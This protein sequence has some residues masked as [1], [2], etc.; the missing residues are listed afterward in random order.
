M[1]ELNGE[2]PLHYRGDCT[3][4]PEGLVFGPDMYGG[5]WKP[6]RAEY[7]PAADRTTMRF[8]PHFEGI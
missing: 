1:T 8:L 3:D 5:R 6:T 4:Y 7:D 2:R